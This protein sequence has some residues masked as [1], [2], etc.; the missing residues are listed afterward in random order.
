M[1][2]V[3][4]RRIPQALAQVLGPLFAPGGSTSSGGVRPG[5]SAP[6]AGKQIPGDIQA[7]YRGAGALDPAQSCDRVNHEARMA[8]VARQGREKALLRVIGQYRRAGGRVGESL[9][10]TAAGVPHGAPL[11]PLWSN[12]R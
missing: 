11:S 8:R 9:Q 6:Q 10:P 5:R 7:G 1:P 3:V 12:V 4:D 2:T